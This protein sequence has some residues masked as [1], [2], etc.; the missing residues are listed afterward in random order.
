MSS[1][2]RLANPSLQIHT[3]ITEQHLTYVYLSNM[4]GDIYLDHEILQT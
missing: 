4:L 1:E 3:Q 2:F